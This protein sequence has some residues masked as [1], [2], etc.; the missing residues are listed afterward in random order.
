MHWSRL[1]SAS[2][3]TKLAHLRLTLLEYRV[4][5]RCGISLPTAEA[6]QGQ[7]PRTSLLGFRTPR[8]AGAYLVRKGQSV[9]KLRNSS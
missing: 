3:S 1:P 7:S 4:S 2:L 6:A 9:V 5:L 8:S